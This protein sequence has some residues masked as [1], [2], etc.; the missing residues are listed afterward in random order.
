MVPS[1]VVS[2]YAAITIRNDLVEFDWI[3]FTRN[4]F[5]FV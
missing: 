2:Q 3:E 4:S 5:N 1:Y